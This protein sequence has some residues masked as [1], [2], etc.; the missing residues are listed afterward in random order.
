M[1]LI[2]ARF[3]DFHRE[4]V[5][6]GTI[7][8]L[9]TQKSM[10]KTPKSTKRSLFLKDET[11]SVGVSIHRHDHRPL[12]AVGMRTPLTIDER[13]TA[14]VKA[15]AAA[16][17]AHLNLALPGARPVS[18]PPQSNFVYYG[19]VRNKITHGGYEFIMYSPQRASNPTESNL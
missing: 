16:A 7:R 19:G 14:N 5:P 12:R 4:Y 9:C 18:I 11:M 2:S 1:G 6:V 17:Q 13:R 15:R 3:D 8:I 10:L